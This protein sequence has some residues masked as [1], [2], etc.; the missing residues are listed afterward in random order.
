ML[1]GWSRVLQTGATSG[2]YWVMFKPSIPLGIIVKNPELAV[3]W[4]RLTEPLTKLA[5]LLIMVKDEP[6]YHRYETPRRSG[7]NGLRTLPQR[8][9]AATV[10]QKKHVGLY[11][12][13]LYEDPSIM[14][15]MPQ[16]LHKRWK[17][18]AS[19][20]F[21]DEDDPALEY[22]HLLF[23]AA[24]KSCRRRGILTTPSP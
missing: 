4:F 17:G 16:I 21:T 24:V 22:V 9:F 20:K 14:N 23:E 15:N 8:P 11:M 2:H 13:S 12:M 10:V 19:L 6:G 3:L 1:G 5:P 7:I 18:K